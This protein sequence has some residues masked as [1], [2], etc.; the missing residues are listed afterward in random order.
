MRAHTALTGHNPTPLSHNHLINPC[1]QS[2]Y[3]KRR[4]PKHTLGSFSSRMKLDVILLPV[5]SL[6]CSR[7]L[8]R[9]EGIYSLFHLIWCL[10]IRNRKIVSWGYAFHLCC[11]VCLVHLSTWGIAALHGTAGFAVSR[12]RRT[13]RM[14]SRLIRSPVRGPSEPRSN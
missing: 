13:P 6:T 7:R 5:L 10:L 1:S 11:H 14:V 9:N 8:R 3:Y 4:S 2:A 12:H